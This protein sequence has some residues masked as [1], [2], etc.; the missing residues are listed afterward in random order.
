MNEQ[1]ENRIADG[2]IGM[3]L[4]MSVLLALVLTFAGCKTVQGVSQTTTRDSV[5]VEYRMDSVYIWQHDSI[6]RDRWR[7]GDTVYVTLTQYKTLYKDKIVLQHDTIALTRTE[8]VTETIS[9]PRERSGYDK[10]TSWFFWVVAVILLLVG[11]FNICDKIPA[12]KPYTAMIRGLF[13]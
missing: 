3:L 4:V 10:F 2:V 5:R 1:K 11:T 12:T 8:T 6:F 13:K 9:V 7:A